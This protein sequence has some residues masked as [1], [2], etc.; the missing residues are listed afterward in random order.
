[1][2]TTE[3]IRAGSEETRPASGPVTA[4]E[5][6]ESGAPRG[7]WFRRS[8]SRLRR[9]E[10]LGGERREGRGGRRR[11]W[12]RAGAFVLPV[13]LV[14]AGAEL[15][16]RTGRL[17]DGP[18]TGNEALVDSQAT[19]RAAAEVSDAVGR[20]FSYTPGATGHTKA[21]AREL[22]AG[23]AKKQYEALFAQVERRVAKQKLTL[24]THVLRTGV[25]R[26]TDDEA[27][28][29]LFLDQVYERD[30]KQA[31]SA[32]AQLTVTAEDRDGHWRIVGIK[33]R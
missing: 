23:R 19:T 33:A 18:A 29:L 9:G 14:L 3:E 2:R 8:R 13:V 24:T 31:T 10:D 15:Q 27:E 22:L 7:R 11:A 5:G 1:M 4:P 25:T 16:A 17:T 26:L 12:R 20:I 28:L 32:A 30:G 6:G 21:A